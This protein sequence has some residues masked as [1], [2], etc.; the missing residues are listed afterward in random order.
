MENAQNAFPLILYNKENAFF[1]LHQLFVG[2]DNIWILENVI[3]L[4]NYVT[5]LT[6]LMGFVLVVEIL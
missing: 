2:L 4:A 6:N 1:H 5:I 3:L